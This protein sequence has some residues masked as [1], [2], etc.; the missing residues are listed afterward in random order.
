LKQ[1][2]S[3]L[4]LP[5]TISRYD[6]TISLPQEYRREELSFEPQLD[7]WTTDDA[8][9]VY[10]LHT[11]AVDSGGAIWIAFPSPFKGGLQSAQIVLSV[12]FG[13]ALLILEG[14][15][16]I[17]RTLGPSMLLIAL[18]VSL[19]AV[20]AAG[21]FVVTLADAREFLAWAAG[22]LVP[23]LIAPFV[24]LWLLVRPQ[25]EA[26]MRGSI[27]LDE[28][29]PSFVQASVTKKDLKSGKTSTRRVSLK[30]DGTYH[31]FVW[32]G[33]STVAAHITAAGGA[34]T[35][36]EKSGEYQ[37]SPKAQIAVPVINV[38]RIEVRQTTT[39]VTAKA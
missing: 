35:S 1:H 39:P 10:T 34:G 2:R 7:K 20:G 18:V 14:K 29:F 38:K 12:I 9:R 6:I 11:S 17:G 25:F 22:P 32:C 13:L 31:T 16:A 8:G 37:L 3:I 27:T 21:Y 24:C 4:N 19:G 30:D 23:V 33:R 15:L 26:E 28:G 5:S 36:E